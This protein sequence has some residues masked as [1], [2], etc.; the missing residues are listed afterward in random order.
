MH[1]PQQID[2][3]EFK[4]ETSIIQLVG[5][6]PLIV[7]AWSHKA[8]EEML[9]NQMKKAKQ[10]REAKDPWMDFCESMYW[11]D[12]MPTPPSR[13]HV[14]SARFGFPAIAFK[15]AAVRAA[16]DAGMKMTEAR[17]TFHID[18][19]LVQ[20]IGSPSMREDM[21]R[22][23]QAKADI[24]Y[25]GEFNPWRVDL[26]VKFNSHVISL[27]QIVNLFE[28]AGFGVGVGEWR[29]EKNGSFGRFHVAREGEI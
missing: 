26:E 22:L 16:N 18:A 14:E 29:P 12:G 11:L 1:M 20:I 24:R 17:R 19:D 27:E 6:S 25:R 23:N 7:H 9:N 10:A 2:L 4:I 8:K 5:D 3:P 15:A 13:K 21:V 28:I